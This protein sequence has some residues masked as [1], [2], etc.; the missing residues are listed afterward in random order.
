MAQQFGNG[1]KLMEGLSNHRL[2][3]PRPDASGRLS[4]VSARQIAARPTT[5]SLD[6]LRGGPVQAVAPDTGRSF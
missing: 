4:P 6:D 1:S 3:N 5:L 2:P